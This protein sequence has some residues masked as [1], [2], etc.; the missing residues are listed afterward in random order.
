MRRIARSKVAE[1]HATTVDGLRMSVLAGIDL[2]Q[3]PE[4][5]GPREMPDSLVKLIV[6]RKIICSMLSNTISGDAWKKAMKDRD[7]A[8]AKRG[9][10]EKTTAAAR[11]PARSCG[12]A[13]LRTP[14]SCRCGG[15][16]L[17]S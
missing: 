17:R 3:H 7:E 6:E 2:I 14:S 15:A 4:I 12:S 1:T 9:E 8:I 16:T 11:A 10:A 5:L 13:R